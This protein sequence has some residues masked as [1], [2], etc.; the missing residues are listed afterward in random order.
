MHEYRSRTIDMFHHWSFSGPADACTPKF[1]GESK[2]MGHASCLLQH[3]LHT[4][5]NLVELN[6]A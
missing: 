4:T 1:Q 5:S 2:T 3:H 6:V